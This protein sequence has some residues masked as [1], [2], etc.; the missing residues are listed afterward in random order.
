MTATT[1][2]HIIAALSTGADRILIDKACMAN[3]AAG[4]SFS[5]WTATGQPGAGA[6]PTTAAVCTK[7]L[8]GA[9]GFTNQTSPVTSYLMWAWLASS[10]A[11]SSIGLHD[12]LAH[13]GGLSGT[14]T[15][16]QGAL[17]IVT[18][19]PGADRLGDA[20]WSDVQW[21]LE[22]YTALGA[23]GVNATVNVTYGDDTTGNLTAIALGA[24]PRAGR[25]Y[26]LVSASPGKFIK[27]VNSV[28]LSA[29]TGT[30]GNFGI[31]ATRG[32]CTLPTIVA[33]KPEI[34]DWA[35]LGNP[36]IPNDSCLFMVCLCTTTSTGTF[37]GAGKI[38][39]A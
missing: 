16:A 36:E 32:R 17:S 14:V 29:T 26:P 2:D 31:T 37:R 9:C 11:M 38:G 35:V 7:A 6:A 25:M 34:Y 21:W 8:T 24:T 13:M 15:T 33:N 18:S 4:Q 28:T 5:L 39:H 3:A 30:A 10:L 23:T 1:R 22:I 27:A 19:S 20:A 12:R